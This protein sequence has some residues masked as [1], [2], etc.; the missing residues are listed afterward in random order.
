MFPWGNED[1]TLDR[2]VYR[3]FWGYWAIDPAGSQPSGASPHGLLDI[4]GN[5]WEW[6]EGWY[7][8]K[9]YEVSLA[10]DPKGPPSGQTH[11]VRGGT[12]DSRPD[13]LS[14]SRRNFGRIGYREGD[15]GF[16]AAMDF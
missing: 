10:R 15:L 12:W 13:V 2:A 14:C 6:C 8:G 5:V 4:A 16:R 7:H 11:V 1:A 9:H 3:R